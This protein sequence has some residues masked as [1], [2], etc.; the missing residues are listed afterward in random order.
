MYIIDKVVPE[1]IFTKY[2][3]IRLFLHQMVMV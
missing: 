1:S 2:E 3:K